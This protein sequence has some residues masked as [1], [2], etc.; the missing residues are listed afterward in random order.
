MKES[1]TTEASDLDETSGVAGETLPGDTTAITSMSRVAIEVTNR[2]YQSDCFWGGPKGIKYGLLVGA[3]PIQQPPLY[4]DQGSTYFVGNFKLPEGSSLTIRGEYGPLRYFSF[5]VAAQLGGGQL[6]N[7]DFLRDYEIEPDEGSANPFSP[8][9]TRDAT[10][11]HYTLRVLQ[12][13]PPSE[14]RQDRP[15]NTIYTT[16]NSYEARIHLALRNYIVDAGYDGTGNATLQQV[17]G[18]GLPEVTL[19]LADG[20]C[21]KGKEMCEVVQASKAREAAGYEREQWLQLV[22]DSWDPTNAPAVSA[23]AFQRFWNVNYN[24]TGAFVLDPVERVLKYPATGAGGFANNPDTIYLAAQ[25]SLDFGQV[26]VIKGKMPTHPKTRHRQR[27]LTPNTQV[28]YWSF[29][30]GGSGPSGVGW[31]SVFDEEVP[32]D[33]NGHFTIVMSWPEDRP[34]NAT[35]ACWVKWIDFGGGEGHYIGARSWVNVVYIRYMTPLDGEDWP[36][37]PMNIPRPTKE[38]P[39]PQDAVVM[40]EYYPRARYMTKAAFEKFGPNKGGSH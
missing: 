4:P 23:P 1:E 10:P 37:S 6:G 16:S 7:G 20:S 15:R 32:V 8:N 29:S 33:E 35:R 30:T 14:D 40:G 17:E 27:T 34:K 13:P 9:N 26:V 22:E 36:Q 28:R 39:C 24:M 25:F 21:L 31:A 38:A 5:T 18:Y 12:G 11:R 19:N 3:L 2:R